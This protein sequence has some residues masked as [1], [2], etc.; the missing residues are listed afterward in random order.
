MKTEEYQRGY[1]DSLTHFQKKYNLSNKN[2]PVTLNQ[3]RQ[4]VQKDTQSKEVTPTNQNKE[5]ENVILSWDKNNEASTSN[6]RKDKEVQSESHKKESQAKGQIENKGI[7]AKEVE[8]QSYLLS[9]EN[10]ISKLKVSIP[11]T[12]LVKNDKYKFQ[13][14]KMLKVDQMS[15]TVNFSDDE[16][17]I[18]F[19][20]TL[21]GS[22]KDSEIPP[23]YLSLKLHYFI[24]HNV[25]LDSSASHNL[26]PKV[27]MEKLGLS[28]TRPYHDIYS[29]DS[30]RVKC[31]GLI[32][33]LLVSMDQI[34]AKNVLM[35]VVVVDIP[36]QFGMLLSR[37]WGTKL[38]GTLQLHFSYATIPVFGKLIKIYRK[39]KM[40]FMISN[41]EKPI[42]QPI[43]G[44][45]TDLDSLI[46]YS[47]MSSIDDN[48]QLVQISE[49]SYVV[50]SVY[51][52]VIAEG[53]EKNEEC[54]HPVSYLE[55]IGEVVKKTE[56][57]EIAS[58]PPKDKIV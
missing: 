57:V 36:P 55:R 26:M 40:K 6:V 5:K 35:D 53:K 38:K 41:K 48:S 10:E 14:A 28:I 27:I 46:L 34:P 29:F 22:P 21:E 20:S 17:A 19:G 44:I 30:R 13:I 39:K 7:T 9:L 54:L 43:H 58:H 12:E 8:K 33:D 2:V 42:N 56:C 52:V 23:F 16:L 4:N 32:K 18:L 51:K 24:L 31:I 1:Q 11:L 25:M 49:I 47:D 45:H 37:S 50:S 3:K 15:D